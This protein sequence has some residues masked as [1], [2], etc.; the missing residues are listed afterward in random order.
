[1]DSDAREITR[2]WRVYRTVHQMCRDRNFL[3]AS[4]DLDRPLD[5]FK[6]EYAPSGKVDR[7][8]LTFVVQK[9][10]DPNNQMFVFFPEEHSVGNKAIKDYLNKMA[11][12]SVNSGIVVYREKLT[13]TAAR[14]ISQ[15][16]GKYHMEK[17]DEAD[18][19]VNI[20]EHELVPQHKVLND[21][22]KKDI[23]KRYRL[24]ETQL[25]RIQLEDPVARYYGMSRGQVVQIIRPSETAGR[26][27]TYR[28][29]M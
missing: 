21:E 20:T 2:L 23:L 22:Q 27:V 9:K 12:E 8:R 28:M 24:K 4:S 5:Q 26:Y 15:V 6:A 7:A 13:P 18:L 17:F 3:V 29:C 11:K 14:I 1:M 25:P 19:L 10:D 16:S